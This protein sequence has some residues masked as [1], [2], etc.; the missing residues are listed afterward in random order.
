MNNDFEFPEEPAAIKGGRGTKPAKAA[1]TLPEEAVSQKAEPEKVHIVDGGSPAYDDTELEAIFD[2]L[3]FDN[4]YTEEV[5]IGGRL[6][7]SLKTRSGK[8]ARE[9]IERVEK[10]RYQMGLTVESVRSL[11][12]L[13]QSAVIINGKDISGEPFDKKLEL[14]EEMPSAVIGAMITALVKFD[15][16]VEAAVTHG[17]A[18]F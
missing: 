1:P 3:L 16:K 10:S 7:I 17:E 15:L 14:I 6:R 2:A 13:V 8:D 4:S 9:V 12:H 18:N 11:C 5:K